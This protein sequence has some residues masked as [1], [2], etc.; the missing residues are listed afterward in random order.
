M[1]QIIS[2]L[3]MSF[4]LAACSTHKDRDQPKP[5][6]LSMNHKDSLREQ[7]NEQLNRAGSEL[8]FE[9]ILRKGKPSVKVVSELNYIPPNFEA[10]IDNQCKLDVDKFSINVHK[11]L[12]MLPPPPA[13]KNKFTKR[14]PPTGGPGK[15]PPPKGKGPNPFHVYHEYQY[16]GLCSDIYVMKDIRIEEKDLG[17][18]KVGHWDRTRSFKDLQRVDM[19]RVNKDKQ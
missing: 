4:F 7:I 14:P 16:Y 19:N 12:I 8:D 1:Q 15:G 10:L 18:K 13:E 9:F 17:Y 3:L 6:H 11:I 2:T 5:L